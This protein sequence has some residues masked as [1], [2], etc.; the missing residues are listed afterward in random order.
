M[1]F[2]SNKLS[3]YDHKIYFIFPFAYLAATAWSCHIWKQ[4]VK[5]ETVNK[6]VSNIEHHKKWILKWNGPDISGCVI[7]E[8]L[9]QFWAHLDWR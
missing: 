4:A 3:D 1:R 5:S 8:R 9:F 2:N 7:N 6:P